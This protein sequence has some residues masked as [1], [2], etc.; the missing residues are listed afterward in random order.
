MDTAC[1]FID[2]DL[3]VFEDFYLKAYEENSDDYTYNLMFENSFS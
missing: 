3:G 1:D 2:Y